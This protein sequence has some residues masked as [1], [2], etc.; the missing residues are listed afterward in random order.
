[1]EVRLDY[2][3]IGLLLLAFALYGFGG[4]SGKVVT[5]SGW[6]DKNWPI[7]YDVVIQSQ[8]GQTLRGWKVYFRV[9]SFIYQ[10]RNDLRVIYD[11]NLVPFYFSGYYMYVRVPDSP[12]MNSDTI[13]LQVYLGNPNARSAANRNAVTYILRTSFEPHEYR[14]SEYNY[15]GIYH[16]G[17]FSLVIPRGRCFEY[18]RWFNS[19]QYGYFYAFFRVSSGRDYLDIYVDGVRRNRYRLDTR[20]RRYGVS[21][22]FPKSGYHTVK[23]CST[24]KDVY[25]DDFM[26]W[27]N[28]VVGSAV[29]VNQRFYYRIDLE[30]NKVNPVDPDVSDRNY[31]V[32]TIST[33][34]PYLPVSTDFYVDGKKVASGTGLH[35]VQLLLTYGDHNVLAVVHFK[36]FD[37][38]VDDTVHVPAYPYD[39]NVHRVGSE[40]VATGK[41]V[42]SFYWLVDG[43]RV[44]GNV[45]DTA[46]LSGDVNVCLFAVSPDNLEKHFCSEMSFS[47]ESSASFGVVSSGSSTGT[48]TNV[49][50]E[51]NH[52]EKKKAAVA[53]VV[54]RS[55]AM[56]QRALAVSLNPVTIGVGLVL[57][58]S[59]GYLL[60]LLIFA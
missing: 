36:N 51:E 3:I 11:G 46:G 56:K 32:F 38:N 22:R 55:A 1:M 59:V 28:T 9:P 43:N 18:M 50:V 2:L 49:S 58:G 52:F 5:P 12:E 8:G 6:W 10:H 42:K 33:D 45:L 54:T 47:S 30:A 23:F 35:F 48:E 40:L 39:I 26:V 17:K 25:M 14:P 13:R 15:S 20:W 21:Y 19:G 41:Y 16:N 37:V 24:S 31:V 44:D 57:A 27:D 29:F 7:R 53:M 60:Y 34:A 4:Y